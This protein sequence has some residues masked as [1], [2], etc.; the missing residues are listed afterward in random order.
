MKSLDPQS[1]WTLWLMSAFVAF[2]PLSTDM[3]LPAL[4]SLVAYFDTTLPAVQWTLSAYLIGFAVFHLLC[5][6]MADRFGRKPILLGG[7]ALFTIACVGCA[8]SE[9]VESLVFWRF[10]QGISACVG[11]TLG[12]A[13]ARDIYGP[14]Q[15][16]KALGYMAAIMA[17]A[18]VIA[19]LL[20][21]WMLTFTGWQAIFWSLAGY[22]LVALITVWLV[23]PETLPKPTQFKLS[24]ILANYR[25]LL[26]HRHFV[27]ST[28][29]IATMYSGA[30]AFISGSSFVLIDFMGV[31]PEHFGWWF[32]LIVAGYMGGSL[33]TARLAHRLDP[34]QTMIGG[35]VLAAS[36]AGIMAVLGA[37]GWHHPLAVVLPMVFYTAAVGSTMPQAMSVALAPFA[38]MAATAS[39]LLGF[40]QMGTAALAGAFVG[41]H[42][43]GT[44]IPMA[45]TMMSGG[46][47]AAGGFWLLRSAS[48]NKRFVE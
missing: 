3:Y 14:T 23:L 40:L 32:M 47:V 4:P 37:I 15:A 9:T 30:F 19:P 35:A 41:S 21:G 46:L 13:M 17:I 36:S 2:G 34:V 1:R 27:I 6:P 20:G 25:F 42:L 5:G 12:R 48:D 11:P 16:A 29:G 45:L 43:D 39:A 7:I 8:L 24:V 44:A 31:P 28:L 33:F 18:P 26:G 38:D 10:I 22:G